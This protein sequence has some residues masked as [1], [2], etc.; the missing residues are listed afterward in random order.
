MMRRTMLMVLVA[1]A[2]FPADAEAQFREI[3]QEI[4]GMD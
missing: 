3:R 2:L 4:Y 1:V